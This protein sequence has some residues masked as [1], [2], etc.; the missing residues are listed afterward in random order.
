MKG[1]DSLTH[2]TTRMNLEDIILGE[3]SQTPHAIGV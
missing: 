1:K 2:A 3:Q